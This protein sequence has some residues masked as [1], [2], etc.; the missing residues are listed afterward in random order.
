MLT[1]RRTPRAGICVPGNGRGSAFLTA[2]FCLLCAAWTASSSAQT[3]TSLASLSPAEG[4][5]PGSLVQGLDG[6]LYGVAYFGGTSRYCGKGGCGT[7]FKLTGA[8][9]ITM[10]H[11][12]CRGTEYPG[13]IVLATDGKFYGTNFQ[14]GPQHVGTVFKITAEGKVA[15]LHSFAGSDGASPAAGVLLAADG[16]FYG[17]TVA[18]GANQAGA[19]FK[20]TPGGV[21]T[22]YSFAGIADGWWPSQ[23]VQGSDGNFYGTF[24]YGG[25]NNEGSIFKITPGGMLTVLHS[26]DTTD[27]GGAFSGV[28]EANNKNFY[29]VTQIGG[30]N[31][32][33]TVFKLTAGGT[34]TILHS[35]NGNDG[36]YPVGGLVQGTDG[37]FYGTTSWLGPNGHGTIFQITPS[38]KLTTLYSFCSQPGCVDG[39]QP[40]TSLVQATDGNFYGTTTAGGSVAYNGTAFK[41]SMG[42]GPFVTTMPV[43][44]PVGREIKILG[45]NLA[46]ATGVNFNGKPA[47]FTV[48]SATEIV[49]HV[50]KGAASGAVTVTTP[51]GTLNSNVSFRVF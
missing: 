30:S 33:G 38:G 47:A 46:G 34:L 31:G 50:P 40:E 16:N 10:Q 4:S 27:G 1:I 29:G 37:N 25:A 51:A 9:A 12:F 48:I 15:N 42:L 5:F 2:V 17:A 26:F 41:L 49:T 11:S 43:S 44:A 18:G 3:F 21:L 8:G 7:L 6:N 32:M 23:L 39:S 14:G 45:T 35:F 19:F 36:E 20:L 24:L 28:I 22:T 13:G